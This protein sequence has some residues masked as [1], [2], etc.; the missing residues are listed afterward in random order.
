MKGEEGSE[1]GVQAT[2]RPSE[3][4]K[5]VKEATGEVEEVLLLLEPVGEGRRDSVTG[6]PA[7]GRPAVV[8]RTWHVIGG[9]AGCCAIAAVLAVAAGGWCWRV[10]GRGAG[11]GGER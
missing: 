8:S 10:S 1:A 9:L 6:I 11:V 5:E 2:T 4:V 7:P 3:L